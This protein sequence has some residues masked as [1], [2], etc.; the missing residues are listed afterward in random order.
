M[1]NTNPNKISS[2]DIDS[3]TAWMSSDG[4]FF[5]CLRCS[6]AVP[7]AIHPA[8]P[9][10]AIP[11]QHPII[12]RAR[13][14]TCPISHHRS[15]GLQGWPALDCQASSPRTKATNTT[16]KPSASSA[17]IQT[18]KCCNLQ[19]YMVAS[20]GHAKTVSG[21]LRPN[22]LMAKVGNWEG[23]T[24]SSSPKP[25]A[26]MSTSTSAMPSD[27]TA[28]RTMASVEVELSLETKPP[29][30]SYVALARGLEPLLAGLSGVC[31]NGVADSLPS[32]ARSS[33]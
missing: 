18:A 14:L 13:M 8:R 11:L 33:W 24:K 1:S 32:S 23:S 3:C 21:K 7:H 26:A 2:T 15:G 10:K 28:K 4:H 25:P 29:N 19:T 20:A 5:V 17:N 30:S 22:N 6:S 9:K 27:S 16:R 31:N 12:P